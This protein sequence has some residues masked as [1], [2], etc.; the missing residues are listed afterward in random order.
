M[1]LRL[2]PSVAARCRWGDRPATC[3][4]GVGRRRRAPGRGARRRRTAADAGPPAACPPWHSTRGEFPGRL[5]HT[6]QGVAALQAAAA[7]DPNATTRR[8]LESARW[9]RCCARAE[10]TVPRTRAPLPGHLVFSPSWS[11][12]R[13]DRKHTIHAERG[14]MTRTSGGRR[15]PPADARTTARGPGL[16]RARPRLLGLREVTPVDEARRAQAARPRSPRRAG[17]G[18]RRAREGS[19]GRLQRV[20]RAL[21]VDAHVI[22]QG[23]T[24][25]IPQGR[26]RGAR[27]TGW[28]RV[29]SSRRA[30]A[31]CGVGSWGRRRAARGWS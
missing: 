29:V 11:A 24:H 14:P 6:D 27:S 22:P 18:A 5:G 28:A 12:A 21:T 10:W 9:T 19:P 1:L 25:V 15:T 17:S 13:A 31:A 4:G 20:R 26:G 16:P 2:P 8:H 3:T 23:W 30:G 7:L